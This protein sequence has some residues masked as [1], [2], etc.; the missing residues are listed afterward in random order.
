MR[1]YAMIAASLLLGMTAEAA[2]YDDAY[3]KD[4]EKRLAALENKSKTHNSKGSLELKTSDTILSVG[5]RIRMEMTYNNPS[6]G[7]SGGSNNWDIGFSPASVNTDPR[8]EE[9]ELAMNAK[10]SRIWL[11]TRKPTQ[12]GVLLTLIEM[13]FYG[14]AGNE[15]GTNSHGPRL[16][17]AYF[18]LGSLTAGQTNSLFMGS[19]APDTLHAPMND[20][21]IRQPQ[22]RWSQPFDE[23]TL[24]FSLEQPESVLL[25]VN[26]TSVVPDDDHMPDIVA[27]Y[28]MYGLWGELSLAGLARQI[29]ADSEEI[30]PGKSDA[31]TGTAFHISGRL[32]TFGLDDLRFGFAAGDALGRYIGGASSVYPV[33][34]IDAAG[35]ITLQNTSGG[36]LSYQHGWSRTLRST[37]AYGYVDADNGDDIPVT[38]DKHA[39]S[40]HVNIQWVPIQNGLIGL[41]YITAHRELENGEKY[42]LDR[43]QFAAS[44]DF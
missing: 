7:G 44:Y 6:V 13:D 17:H 41:E 33:G 8:G 39:D 12:Y 29:R 26:G 38:A 37:L 23:S 19:G 30:A 11:K 2:V 21:V 31:K 42:A 35:E 36:H 25:D 28:V 9:G 32:K 24:H 18:T 40:T 1:R 10:E 16:R 4:L 20:I 34:S 15:K 22:I 43:I 27:K 5:G 14:A 3:I